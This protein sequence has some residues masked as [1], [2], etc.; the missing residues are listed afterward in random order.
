[1]RTVEAGMRVAGRGRRQGRAARGGAHAH[2]AQQHGAPRARARLPRPA[3]VQRQG[4]PA[5]LQLA[6]TPGESVGHLRA[7]QS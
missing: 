7:D 1:M 5:Q 6:Q 2:A 4:G 3:L